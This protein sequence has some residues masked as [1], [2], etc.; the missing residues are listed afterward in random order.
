MFLSAVFRHDFQFFNTQR[1]SELYEKEVR[2]LMVGAFIDNTS[3]NLCPYCLVVLF[4]VLVLLTYLVSC[5]KISASTS[6]ES[7]ER[8]N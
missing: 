8:Y 4:E 1:L 3:F 2:H 6:K 5:Y 7:T